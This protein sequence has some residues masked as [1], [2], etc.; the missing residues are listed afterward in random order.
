MYEA[1]KLFYCVE[2]LKI[3]YFKMANSEFVF[4]QY[5]N[6]YFEKSK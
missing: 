6:D 4:D 1:K 5:E 2:K 3:N